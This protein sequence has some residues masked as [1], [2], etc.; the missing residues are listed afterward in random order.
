MASEGL[1]K[2]ISGYEDYIRRKGVDESVV[3]AYSMAVNTAFFEE[4]DIEYGKKL[5][6]RAKAL[7]C[8]FIKDKT[9]STPWELEKYCFKNKTNYQ[10]LDTFYSVL[11]TEAQHGDLESYLM[12][13][14][15]KR[16][17]KDRFYMPKRK[18]LRKIGLIQ[19]LQ[20]MI[21][22]KADILCISMPPG[23]GKAQPLYS[24]VLT[25]NGFVCMGDIHVGDKVI[26]GNG[27]A[28]SVIGVFPQGIKPIYELTFDDGSKCRCSDE[29][30]WKVQTRDDRRRGNKY[31]V[32]ELSK[33]LDNVKIEQGKR[34]NYSVDYI[35]SGIEFDEQ[36]LPL[37]PYVLGVL[38]GD[39]SITE[40]NLGI[41]SPDDDLIDRF[42]SLL[43][44]GYGLNYAGAYDFRII[45]HRRE[46]THPCSD[47]RL[48]LVN[49]GLYGKKSC[50]KFIPKQY[51]YASRESRLELLR[52]LMDTD[53]SPGVSAEYSTASK[54]LAK[55]VVE[56]VHSLGGYA[57]IAHRTNCGYI[58]K[59]GQKV[60]CNDSYRLMVQFSAEDDNPFWLKRKAKAYNPKRGV[61]KRF[62]KDIQYVGEEECQCIMI[63][64]PCHLYVTDDYIITHNT[65][66]SKFFI[67]GVMGWYPNDY[68]L[69]FSHSA[70]ICRMY[71][72]GVLSIINDTEYAWHD[73]FPD[74]QVTGTNAKMMNI[75]IGNYKPFQN[76]MCGSRGSELAGKVRCSKF[77]MVD[78]LIGKQEEALNKNILEKIWS[79]DYTTDA[80]QRKIEGCKEVHIAT[81]WSV[82][83]VI[84]R[85]QMIYGDSD[86]ARFIA[87]PDIDEET[88][89]SNFDYEFGGFS[90]E[91]FHSQQLLMDDITYG[92][93]YKQQPM[94]REGLL[95]HEEDLRRYLTLPERE[96]D[97]ILGICDTKAKGTDFMF[98]P[99]CY[100]YDDDYY[101]VDCVCNDSSDFGVQ[102]ELCASL[103]LR[104]N[105][106]QCQFESNVGGD[107]FASNVA[108][109][110]EQESGR[111]NI[112]TK[113]TE[114]NK[115]TKIIVN[116]DWV[117]KHVLFKDKSMY[118][119]KDEYGTMMK[120]LISYSVTGKNPHDDIPDGWAM[121]ALF[122]TAG[123]RVAKVEAVMN[124]FRR[125]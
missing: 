19:G 75:N 95:Y 82:Y 63:D 50:E 78:D 20:D 23:T 71:Y 3:N 16:E 22:D 68:N 100:Q 103:I 81:R 10:I 30:L 125:M 26:A 72:D 76:L 47:V 74:L 60:I 37:H 92:C 1:I 54:Q 108:K 27:K 79:N 83:D 119:P 102:E 97:A 64:D 18:Q 114:S 94:E 48:A 99:C 53:G 85:L 93:L 111:C 57:S 121:F 86:R 104:H 51:L 2:V 17:P 69:F 58:G 12:C 38:I 96:P 35:K 84:G 39:G 49:L 101:C 62:I 21:D 98:L 61:I 56:L 80:L 113:P 88:G 40:G 8:I 6:R 24:K 120:W 34:L 28:S 91:F 41:S 4:G 43:P 42:G 65:T 107:R 116:A 106:Q 52:G 5:S 7:I 13:L 15:K 11:K 117:K 25:P 45:G 89:K 70:D 105:M 87:V 90:E 33:M 55:D 44:E 59:D 118:S 32:V 46:G 67:S 31:R 115:E 109:K 124:P 123:S 29:H 77:L 73:I 112:T 9:G 14:E 66:L 110:V 36:D 122:A